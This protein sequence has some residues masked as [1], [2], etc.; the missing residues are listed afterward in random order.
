VLDT[1]I[2]DAKPG[3]GTD[4]VADLRAIVES[5]DIIGTK[6]R[7]GRLHKLQEAGQALPEAASKWP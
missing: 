2:F 5:L 6:T 3:Q 7:N 4:T 1:G